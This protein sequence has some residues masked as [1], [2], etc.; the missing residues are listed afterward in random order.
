MSDEADG[1]EVLASEGE[2]LQEV[3][4]SA[5]GELRTS[6]QSRTGATVSFFMPRF[7]ANL[8]LSSVTGV[9]QNGSQL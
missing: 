8:I 2:E 4:E 9:K 5:F 3:D 1:D 7:I 6:E